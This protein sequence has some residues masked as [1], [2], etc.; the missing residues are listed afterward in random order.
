MVLHR[1]WPS[2]F[3]AP[4][5]IPDNW[6]FGHGDYLQIDPPSPSIIVPTDVPPEGSSKPGRKLLAGRLDRRVRVDTLPLNQMSW[7][8]LAI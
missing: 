4:F 8:I 2:N 5:E 1:P 6:E 7:C 3:Q